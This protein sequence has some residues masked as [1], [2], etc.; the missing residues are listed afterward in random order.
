MGR[1][2]TLDPRISMNRY[3]YCSN[4]PI[5]FVDPT[6]YDGIP[7]IVKKGYEFMELIYSKYPNLL[8][9]KLGTITEFRKRI[10]DI[11]NN[12]IIGEIKNVK[13]QA[14]TRQIR[15]FIEIA[16][17]SPIKKQFVLI[18]EE[19][20]K[21]SKNLI[22]EIKEIG[23]VIIKISSSTGKVTGRIRTFF[24]IIDKKMLDEL[25]KQFSNEMS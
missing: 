6:G 17:K 13:Y 24:F 25:M 12:A 7:D 5:T 22:R 14:L 20:T 23:G 19:N 16:A 2:L 15:G 21:L 8:E 1:F 10:P 11:V 4:N 18:V 9:N 3:T